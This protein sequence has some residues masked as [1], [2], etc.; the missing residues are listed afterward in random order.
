MAA[1]QEGTT[2]AK[3]IDI[4]HHFVRERAAMGH[5]TLGPMA[6][7][8]QLADGLT[9]PL[10]A[11]AFEAFRDHLDV[12]D[13]ADGAKTNLATDGATGTRLWGSVGLRPDSRVSG[14]GRTFV[15]GNRAPSLGGI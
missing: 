15:S 12:V 13:G 3:H 5:I 9:R 10:A 7:T 1:N 14:V 8:E 11:S 2:R 4:A 6:G